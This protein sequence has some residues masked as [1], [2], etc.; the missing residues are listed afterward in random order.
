MTG[1]SLAGS[2]GKSVTGLRQGILI[3]GVGYKA[4]VIKRREANA[5]AYRYACEDV[6]HHGETK[7]LIKGNN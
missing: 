5:G 4:G 2:E 1:G 3:Q 6:V 7:S